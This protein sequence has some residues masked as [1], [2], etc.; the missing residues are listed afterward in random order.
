MAAPVPELVRD[1]IRKGH[2]DDFIVNATGHGVADVQRWRQQIAGT[3]GAKAAMLPVTRLV[4][5]PK[6]IRQSLGDLDELVASIR[7]VGLVQPLVVTPIGDDGNHQRFLVMAGHRRLAAAKL[8]P[9][10]HVPVVIRPELSDHHAVELML[11][12]NL[13]RLQLNPIEE[14]QGY[15]VLKDMGRTQNEIAVQLGVNQARVSQRLA[16]LRLT[17]EEQQQVIDGELGIVR[18]YFAGRD[19]G[20]EPHASR[21]TS[22]ARGVK[23][24]HFTTTHPLATAAGALCRAQAHDGHYR[25][26]PACGQ[27]WEAVIREDERGRRSAATATSSEAVLA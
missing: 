14:A 12:E 4:P 26:G 6:N 27:C 16:L 15:Q 9:V 1:F 5:H 7:A 19:R 17:P 10:L 22:R 23:V 20:A 11:V 2:P 13:Q 25:I 24:P 3:T 18:A 8:V 21:G